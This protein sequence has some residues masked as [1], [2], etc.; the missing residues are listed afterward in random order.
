MATRVAVAIT[1]L[2]RAPMEHRKWA[3]KH[4]SGAVS[5]SLTVSTLHPPELLQFDLSR[6]CFVARLACQALRCRQRHDRLVTRG[7]LKARRPARRPYNALPSLAR[8]DVPEGGMARAGFTCSTKRYSTSLGPS[9]RAP[10]GEFE[11]SVQRPGSGVPRTSGRR[12]REIAR[13]PSDPATSLEL[14]TR[15][16]C[17]SGSARFAA[18]YVRGLAVAP[19]SPSAANR[20]APRP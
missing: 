10:L 9:S 8:R 18:G 4:I 15:P 1:G 14:R 11:E 16:R 2:P 5:S 13:S 12:S 6:D 3:E 17:C 20:V 7:S 19:R